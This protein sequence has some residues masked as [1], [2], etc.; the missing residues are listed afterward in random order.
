MSVT[1]M[2]RTNGRNSMTRALFLAMMLFN[3]S[4]G[5]VEPSINEIDTELQTLNLR[6]QEMRKEEFNDEMESQESMRE[7]WA[8]FAKKLTEAENDEKEQDQIL[9][10]MAELQAKKV[11]LLKQKP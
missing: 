7:N 2:L 1:L 5:S 6:L 11:E 8:A 3:I 10:R 4:A 9:K